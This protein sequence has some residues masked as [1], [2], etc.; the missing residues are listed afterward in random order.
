MKDRDEERDLM[1]EKEGY[2]K[3]V[4]NIYEETD[5]ASRINKAQKRWRGKKQS[6]SRPE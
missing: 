4:G 2:D 1:Y 3:D 5:K 6:R